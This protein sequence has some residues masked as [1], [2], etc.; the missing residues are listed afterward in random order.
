MSKQTDLINIP[1]AITVDGSNV[2]IGTSSPS[3]PKFSSGA[4]GVLE[5]KGTK[6]SFNVQE[7]D[8][9]NAHFNMSMNG[10]NAYLGATGTGNLILATGTADWSERMRID[11]SG[12]VGIGTSPSTD[13]RTAFNTTATQVGL[14]GSL[15]NLDVSTGDRRCMVSSNAILNA[16]GDFQHILEG[17]ATIYSQQSGTHRWYTAPSASA[18]ATA[19]ASERLRIDASGNV[20]VGKTTS[21]S[22]SEGCELRD[23]GSSSGYAITAT[24]NNNTTLSLNRTNT[25]GAIAE[26]RRDGTVHGSIGRGG[27]GFYISGIASSDFGVLFDGSGLISCTGTGVIR[28]NQYNIG[29]GAYRWTNIYATNGSINTSDQTE[30][31][32][33]ASLTATEMLVAK[34][35]SAMFKNYRWKDKV[36]TEGDG[37]RNHTGIIAQDVQA[38]FTAESLDASK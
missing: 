2:G 12:N 13:W 30:K 36:A 7:S 31:Q 9:T 26:F 20:L 34:R 35:I 37:A 3:S 6:P 28:D 16:S 1:D 4:S 24:S 27:S 18:G 14:T 15:F 29:H 10:G 33:I 8:V 11:S 23:G 17:H 5:L 38:A 19:A 22:S 32:D 25:N 21:S